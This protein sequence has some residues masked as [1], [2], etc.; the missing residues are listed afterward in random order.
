MDEQEKDRVRKDR[1]REGTSTK[2][3][4]LVSV[5]IMVDWYQYINEYYMQREVVA[6]QDNDAVEPTLAA[7][8]IKKYI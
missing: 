8:N 1:V 4:G 3:N 7:N 2:H 6:C 5:H